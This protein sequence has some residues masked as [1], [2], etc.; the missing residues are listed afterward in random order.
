MRRS[1]VIEL[2]VRYAETDQMG[3]VYHA[4]Y[5]VW[6][7]MGRTEHIRALGGS[8]RDLEQTGVRLAVTEASLRYHAPARY[9]D[10]VRVRTTVADVGS[11]SVT[12][13]YELQH[14]DTGTRLAT[15]TTTLVSLDERGVVT[16][17]PSSLR[18]ALAEH[19]TRE[20]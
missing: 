11:R 1:T 14:V 4:N 6:C 16:R 3:V 10:R 9:D 15:A 8:Y 19:D 2:R 7:D 20:R 13:S 18:A 12:F 5:L 17:L